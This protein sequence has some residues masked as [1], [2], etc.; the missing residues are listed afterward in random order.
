VSVLRHV[1]SHHDGDHYCDRDLDEKQNQH[2][3]AS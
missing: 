1:S 3:H 2:F